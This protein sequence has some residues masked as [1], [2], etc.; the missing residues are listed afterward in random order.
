M[1]DRRVLFILVG[2]LVLGPAATGRA[3]T[4]P[5]AQDDSSGPAY[6]VQDIETTGEP[7]VTPGVPGCGM[8]VCRPRQLFGSRPSQLL[9]VG[10]TLYF[11]AD[12]RVHGSELWR[13]DGKAAGT[14]L[15]ADVCPGECGSSP[16]LIGA[17]GGEVLFWADDGRR[18]GELWKSDGTPE[19]TILLRDLCPGECGAV[20]LG[21]LAWLDELPLPSGVL[22]GNLF[23]RWNEELWRSDG[24]AAGTLPVVE[25]CA[26]GGCEPSL[27]ELARLGSSLFFSVASDDL[28]PVLWR[29]DGAIDPPEPVARPCSASESIRTHDLTPLGDRLVFDS[30][31]LEGVPG[32]VLYVTDGTQ[33][34]THALLD[35]PGTS[36]AAPVAHDARLSARALVTSGAQRVYFTVGLE[37]WSTDGTRPGTE[38]VIDLP[39]DLAGLESLASIGGEL[40][41]IGVDQGLDFDLWVT[42]DDRSSLRKLLDDGVSGLDLAFDD[43]LFLGRS[44]PEGGLEPWITDGTV[45]GTRRIQDVI[46]GPESS[47]P[48][49]PVRV[50]S[51][52]FFT[53]GLEETGDRELWAFPLSTS[54]ASA[55]PPHPPTPGITS[56]RARGFRFWVRITG[57]QGPPRAGVQEP[58][59]LPETVCVSGAVPGRSEV[60]LRI[61]GPK[62]NGRLWPTLVKF[63]TSTVEVWI[64][65]K[66]TGEIEYYRLPGASPGVDELPGR[67]DRE[68]FA[69]VGQ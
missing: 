48:R 57:Q 44:E 15:V 49:F 50:G 28:S 19:G 64:E 12:D 27:V 47:S 37:I 31:C 26:E 63:S 67:F 25:L 45:A 30:G 20:E 52:I 53:A 42:E 2:V 14:E 69:P 35:R 59:C 54:G 10:S 34:G 66:A 8:I 41:F 61:V 56:S 24:T 18:G 13:S 16:R 21:E 39:G 51:R 4:G 33:E 7:I 58:D 43:L 65:Q 3:S 38:K 68:G 11:V 22:D 9:A 17:L 23:F 29:L 36:D 60:F 40:A 1:I 55:G 6:L 5:F 46:A 32:G 62:P